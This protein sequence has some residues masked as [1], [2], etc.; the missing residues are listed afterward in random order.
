MGQTVHH[1][2]TTYQIH[3]FSVITLSPSVPIHYTYAHTNH[4]AFLHA[5]PHLHSHTHMG[6]THQRS[7]SHTTGIKSGRSDRVAE[8]V[9]KGLTDKRW[10]QSTAPSENCFESR[11]G[12]I[13]SFSESR[14]LFQDK[15]I[16]AELKVYFKSLCTCNNK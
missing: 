11:L 8:W 10:L 7:T 13:E 6:Y 15:K 9:V 2:L 4:P 14:R 1:S 5:V 16:T 12:W 3:K